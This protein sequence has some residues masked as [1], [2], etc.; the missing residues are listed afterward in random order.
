MATS[1]VIYSPGP[2][3][4][5]RPAD[6]ISDVDP[7][8]VVSAVVV[9][10]PGPTSCGAALGAPAS[11]G[12]RG[13]PATALPTSPALRR[14]ALASLDSF[15]VLDKMPHCRG[16]LRPGHGH[17]EQR[18]EPPW[19][20]TTTTTTIYICVYRRAMGL[21][22]VSTVRSR[23][24]SGNRHSYSAKHE[25]TKCNSQARSLL[26]AME[27]GVRSH[28]PSA[29]NTG[30]PSPWDQRPWGAPRLDRRGT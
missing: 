5:C 14:C 18:P 16:P 23:Q 29:P 17:C 27:G 28:A 19:A 7:A 21:M 22:G 8:V 11:A 3:R 1:V 9:Y 6:D 20:T 15:A 25:R 24:N 26:A 30:A 12:A 4:S 10:S 2:G 13:R